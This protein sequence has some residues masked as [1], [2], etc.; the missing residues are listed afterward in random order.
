LKADVTIGIDVKGSTAGFTGVCQNSQKV[1]T[2]TTS[3]TRKER[4]SFSK[5]RNVL[6]LGI[7]KVANTAGILPE[8]VVVQRDGRMF[9]S[10]LQAAQAALKILKT[11][12]VVAPNAALTCVEIPKSGT[13][14]FRFFDEYFDAGGVRGYRNPEFGIY[15]ILGPNEGH[16]C[17]TGE[18]FRVPG[19]VRP[20]HVKRVY[21]EMPIEDCLRDVFYL[22]CLTWSKPDGCSRF[23]VTVRLNDR[24]LIDVATP[25]DD[26]FDEAPEPVAAPM[27]EGGVR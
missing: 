11:D 27:A 26:E 5:C 14:A 10:E 19:T 12:S 24:Q 8:Q 23:P 7:R 17:N 16:V 2:Q 1:W 21:G 15:A 4:L 9:E 3:T 6:V 18:S 13:A 22:A 20:L 25:F